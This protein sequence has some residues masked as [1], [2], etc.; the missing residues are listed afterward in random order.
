M[1]SL[2]S[3]FALPIVL[4]ALSCGTDYPPIEKTITFN[5]SHA[6]D[7]SLSNTATSNQDTSLSAVVSVDTSQYDKNGTTTA[8]LQTAKVTRL[9]LHSS[10]PN[11][12]LDKLGT[13]TVLID[14][15]TVAIDP[16]PTG[17]LDTSLILTGNDITKAMQD[18]SFVASLR[19]HPLSSPQN[20]LTITCDLSVT[21][22]ANYPI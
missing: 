22:I 7:F 10:D 18:T 15:D 2:K 5:M 3:V 16:M 4:F 17:T 12:T 8:L 14:A 21:Y 6:F 13:I 9:I 1:R 19:C 11:F 20:P